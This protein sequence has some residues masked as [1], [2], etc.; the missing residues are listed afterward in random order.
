LPPLR[1]ADANA[2][3]RHPQFGPVEHELPPDV[4]WSFAPQ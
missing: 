2:G 3:V 4:S 1:G